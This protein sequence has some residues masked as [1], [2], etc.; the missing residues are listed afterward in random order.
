MVAEASIG[1]SIYAWGG[2]SGIEQEYG[3]YLLW[4]TRHSYF[5]MPYAYIILSPCQI[6]IRFIPLGSVER[7]MKCILL[8]L[9][10]P[11]AAFAQRGL[12]PFD[13]ASSRNVDKSA[14]QP[15]ENPSYDTPFQRDRQHYVFSMTCDSTGK[16]FR[17][18][19]PSF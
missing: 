5:Y 12:V 18:P 7:I 11:M 13:L 10:R 1:S 17:N 2:H 4:C 16:P 19:I 6:I 15:H 8:T 9:P 3:K 14:L